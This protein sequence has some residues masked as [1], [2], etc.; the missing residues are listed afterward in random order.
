MNR[1]KEVMDH[2][3]RLISTCLPFPSCTCMARCEIQNCTRHVTLLHLN[4]RSCAVSADDRSEDRTTSVVS[5]QR[6]DLCHERGLNLVKG[7]RG[8]ACARS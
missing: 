5:G 3:P 2:P 8:E 4:Q 7:P 6:R 1:R